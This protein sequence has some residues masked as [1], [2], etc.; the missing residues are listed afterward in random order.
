MLYQKG[1]A[2]YNEINDQPKLWRET[3]NRLAAGR[4][5]IQNW[6]RGENFGQVVFLGCGA[7]YGVALAAARVTHRVSGLNA[8]ALP[9][10]EM[11]YLNRPPYDPRIKTLLIPMSRQGETPET[12]WAV[13]KLRKLNNT[14]KALA[15]SVTGGSL[16]GLCDQTFRL[17]GGDEFGPVATKSA[18]TMLLTAM[19]LGCF[20]AAGKA[21]P[22]LHEMNRVPEMLDPKAIADRVRSIGTLKP[23]PQHA[24]F[25]GTG[26]YLG[27]AALG[28]IWMRQMVAIPGEYQQ[29]LEYRN[30]SHCGLTNLNLVVALVSDTLR[31]YEEDVVMYLAHSRVPRFVLTEELSQSARRCEFP[32]EL[33]SGVS[34]LSRLLITQVYVQLMCYYLAIAKGLNP[35]KPKLMENLHILKDKPNF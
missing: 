35:D 5:S 12:L 9:S 18:S 29:G 33:K 27:I 21:D 25:L 28:S 19:V 15:I 17:D 16:S 7:A 11:L 34:E 14:C 8:V 2:V 23:P 1:Q 4:E 3:L 24:V 10:S 22:L 31:T 13:E 20:L 26:P 32:V 6:L 30:G